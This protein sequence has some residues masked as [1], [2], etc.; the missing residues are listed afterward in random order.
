MYDEFELSMEPYFQ[1]KR[2]ITVFTPDFKENREL[3]ILFVHDGQVMLGGEDTMKVD[4]YIMKTRLNVMVVAIHSPNI[5]EERMS[6]LCP[7]D[8]RLNEQM[9]AGKGS[10][11]VEFIINKVKPF[12]EESFRLKINEA[13]MFGIS[14]GGLLSTY[15]A[16]QYPHLFNKIACM[17]SAYFRNFAPLVQCIKQ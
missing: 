9:I 10:A 8:V 6:E 16:C 13:A 3:S 15:A 14:L 4:E 11:Y 5:L 7:W 2:K 1:K 12:I 17:S